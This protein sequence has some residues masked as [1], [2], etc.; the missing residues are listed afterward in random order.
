MNKQFP[1]KRDLNDGFDLL[2]HSIFYT[3]Q[4]E[5]PFSGKPA[6]F[7]RLGGCNLQCSG[8]DTEYTNGAKVMSV[9]AIFEEIQKVADGRQT[10][11]VVISGGEPF[12]QNIS[13]L[14]D[15]LHHN[16]VIAQIET[17]GVLKPQDEFERN[18]IVICSPKTP[19]VHKDMYPLIT[20]YK[21]VL[22]HED[23]NDRDGLPN[24]ALGHK[25]T[26]HVA[27]PHAGFEGEVYIQPMDMTTTAKSAKAAEAHN[28]R[29][30]KACVKSAMR[31]NYRM[32]LQ[33]H[34]LLGLE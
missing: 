16:K 29:N 30:E 11:L 18:P 22:D 6:V 27:R 13:Y 3:L 14:V 26:P 9:I 2:V 1:M 28:K 25:A 23:M 19:N 15:Q 12:R 7:V 20:A 10:N 31:F 17:N 34:K 21:Y 33:T 32:Q 5:G 24:K 8:C 4:G